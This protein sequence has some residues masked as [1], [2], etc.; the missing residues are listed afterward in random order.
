M[1][2]VTVEILEAIVRSKMKASDIIALIDSCAKKPAPIE[3]L[4]TEVVVEL[5]VPKR[6]GRPPKYQTRHLTAEA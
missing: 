1:T 5:S 2:D 6:R 4:S 3:A